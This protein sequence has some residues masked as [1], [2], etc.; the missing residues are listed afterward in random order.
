MK[1]FAPFINLYINYFYGI[2][3]KNSN[4]QNNSFFFYPPSASTSKRT[5]NSSLL[6]AIITGTPPP[7][8]PP[9]FPYL[10]NCHLGFL[11]VFFFIQSVNFS[12]YDL[13][14][15]STLL[16]KSII[17]FPTVFPSRAMKFHVPPVFCF[18][19]FFC[20]LLLSQL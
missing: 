11:F 16:V 8:F 3:A 1:L 6:T 19:F 5:S 2:T 9:K 14:L 4:K 17:S 18:R 13:D 7:L 20:L 12:A 15:L 10:Y